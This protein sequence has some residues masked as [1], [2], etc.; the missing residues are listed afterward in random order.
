MARTAA[1]S[2]HSDWHVAGY[3]P[4]PLAP[5]RTEAELLAEAD[6]L[7]ALPSFE[8]AV[9]RYTRDMVAFREAARPY[10]KLIANED[11]FRVVNFFFPL[12]AESLASGGSGALTYGELYEVCR[13]GEVTSRVLKNTLA[14]A[15]HLGFLTRA[16]NPSDRRSRLY[17]PTELMVRFPY[18]WMVPATVAIDMLIPGPSLTERIQSDFRLLIHF[19]RSAGREFDAGL[20]PARLVP[21]F[22]QF[23]GHKEGATLLAMSLLAAEMAELPYPT[24]SEVAEQFALTK[25]QVSQLVATGVEMGFF[26]ITEGVTHPTDALREGHADW[27]AVALAF[28]NHHLRPEVGATA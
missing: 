22:M 21:R 9:K 19:F 1:S 16:P 6:A 4:P 10:G 18:Q 2:P 12:W 15:V 7:K 14:L 8:S 27:V 17:A 5:I 28:L 25:S 11:R 3:E 13:R 24:R 20:Q 26:A 23:S